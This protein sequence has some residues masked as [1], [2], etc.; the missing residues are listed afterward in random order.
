MAGLGG[1]RTLQIMSVW[2]YTLDTDLLE[3]FRAGRSPFRV[4]LKAGSDALHKTVW[5]GP[6]VRR[7]F[8]YGRKKSPIVGDP[9]IWAF[10]T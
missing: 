10:I 5:I 3:E 7:A 2:F 1:D 4:S 6:D 8:S 9:V